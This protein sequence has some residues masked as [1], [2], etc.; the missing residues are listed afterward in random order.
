MRKIC[1][2]CSKDDCR[3]WYDEEVDVCVEE[4]C[5][6]VEEEA[7]GHGSGNALEEDAGT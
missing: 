4:E 6:E 1:V 7:G 2:G 5:A 3:T